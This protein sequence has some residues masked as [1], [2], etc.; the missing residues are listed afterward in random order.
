MIETELKKKEKNFFWWSLTCYRIYVE[1]KGQCV[2]VGPVLPYRFQESNSG[3]QTC[4]QVLVPT[5]PTCWTFYS[6]LL[7]FGL[8]EDLSKVS[9]NTKADVAFKY[10]LNYQFLNLNAQEQQYNNNPVGD[11][12]R[13]PLVPEQVLVASGRS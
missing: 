7:M 8:I 12:W 2:G 10:A 3:H 9:T 6:T 13:L 5:E 11:E 1:I 4:Q